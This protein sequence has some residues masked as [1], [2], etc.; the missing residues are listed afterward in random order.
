[1]NI[2]SPRDPLKPR[3]INPDSKKEAVFQASRRLFVER[4]Y[5][6]VSI[7]DI[8]RAS[9][10][11]TGAIYRYFPNKE[12]MARHIHQLT[13]SHFQ[14]MY[15]ER[16]QGKTGIFDRLRTFAELVF[17]LTERDP[18]MMAYLLFMRHGEFMPGA[19]PLCFTAP[20]KHIRDTV[21]EGMETGA[22]KEGDIFITAVCFTG[23]ILRPADLRLRCVLDR[24]LTEVADEIIAN[25]WA[26][27]RA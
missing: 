23:V 6:S 27:I 4:G 13:L 7:P 11:S 20:F 26:A 2:L 3:K 24:P 14:A 18:D 25:A 1:M 16:L 10:V 9:G 12:A 8:V 5:H 17:D 15:E 22:I 21:A 19:E